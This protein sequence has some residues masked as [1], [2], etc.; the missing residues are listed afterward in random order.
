MY[1]PPLALRGVSLKLCN[2]ALAVSLA[3]VLLASMTREARAQ[4]KNFEGTQVHPLAL[5][6][7]G[8][9][10]LAVN[11]PAAS[12][13][14]FQLTPGGPV[15]T[16]EIPVGFE[17]VS[18][19]AR[20]NREAWVVNWLSDSVSIVDLSTGN[21][22]R[23]IDVGDEPTDVIFAG[24]SRAM[25]FVCVSG[26]ASLLTTFDINSIGRGQVKVFDAA[27]PA[28]FP[29]TIEIF[30][31]Q[32]RALARSADG[33]R[34]F[35]SVFESGN[36][37][38]VVPETV[39]SANGGLPPPSIPVTAGGTAPATSLIVKWS[40]SKWL[41]EISRDWT[42]FIPYTLADID[43]AVIDAS[44]ANLPTASSITARVPSL[45]T[46]MG[47]MVFDP[48][49]QRLLVAN[50]DD[51]NNERFEPVV[52]GRFQSSRVSV[53]NAPAGTAP[54]VA[55]VSNLN[56]HVNEADTAGTDAE[57]ALSLALPADIAR[58][59]DG[60]VYVAATSSAKV[61]VLD[62]S[63]AVQ[64]RIGVGNGPTGLAVDDARGRLYVL[65]RFDQTLSVVDTASKIQTAVVPVGF[66]I[67]PPSVR[68]G[69]RFLYDATNFS[70]HG[71][72]SCASCHPNGHRDGLAW[73]L[74]NPQGTA[75]VVNTVLG[76]VSDH[77][78]KGPMTTQ[79]LRGLSGVEPLHWRGDRAGIENFNPAFVSL[80]GSTRQLTAQEMADFKAFVQSLTYPP[81]PNEFLGR[82]QA[83]Q[84]FF[85][86]EPLDRNIAT[87]SSCHNV[88]NFV[89]G[90]NKTII[91]KEA[92]MKT[93]A[94]KVPQLRG[95]YQ[96]LGMDKTS[97]EKLTGFGFGHDGTFDTLFNFQTAPQFDFR[98]AGDVGTANAWRSTIERM[99]LQL[100]TG[101]PPA[102]G[103][104]VTVDATN[105][106]FISITNDISTLIQQAAVGNCD[107]V[108]RGLYGGRPRSFL[109]V[110]P[111]GP[112]QFQPDTLAEAPVSLQTLLNAVGAN[113]EL[114]FMGV[115]AGE[116]PLFAL[117]QDG[118]GILNDDEPRTSVSISG[119]VVNAS[120]AP[121]AGVAVTLS[122]SQTA[123]TT[124]DSLGRFLFT[125]ASVSGTHTVTPAAQ[126]VT[127]EPQSRT[128]AT[129]RADQ[130][131]VFISAAAN[132]SDSSEFFVRQH[133]NDFFSREPD[134]AG[135][136]FWINEIES[137]GASAQ[138]REV[139]RINVSGAFFL[140]IEFQ[141][142]GFLVYK[143]YKA[144]FGDLAGKPV[145][146]TLDQLMTD[147]QRIGRNLIV[148][149]GDWQTLL[150][151]NKRAF[152]LG[153]VQRP[154]FLARFPVGTSAASFV[155]ALN[156]NTGGSL[157]GERDAIV[158]QLNSNNTTQGR[159]TALRSVVEN[160]EFTRREKNRA[161]VLMQ[162]FG[163]L[164]RNPDDAPQI[165]L[166]FEGY[167]FWLGKLDDNGGDFVHAEMVKAFLSSD[168][169]RHRFG[170]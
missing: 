63:G 31:K 113:A 116:G 72:V 157:G 115:P 114:T 166:N 41:D 62:A 29:T 9:R 169:Y 71:T 117:D 126:G 128:F 11:T 159:A 106:S 130:S 143:S 37:T 82:P 88:D 45:G 44:G 107:L 57:R 95:L 54:T 19:A 89:P 2:F 75:D 20:N 156:A 70:A 100:D 34:V 18:V 138:C 47:N 38:T 6:P 86:N 65:N 56:S 40:G 142:T 5:T 49:S 99:I 67:E 147:T 42:S 135:L 124:T 84:S 17:P 14:V 150:E 16:A 132:A 76:Q 161:F 23:T 144:S 96:K 4:F 24:S 112:L 131:G 119:R 1:P 158:N 52:R 64:T 109:R 46:H 3:A 51:I 30:G 93:Q 152:F 165:G 33:S 12:L 149:Q 26:G 118:N 154:E 77:P 141:Q 27:N 98:S 155:D 32:P 74:G 133:Y 105:K 83:N 162:Y 22:V 53:L 92:L 28:S 91:N 103:S 69:R 123:T 10:L 36:Q 145:P 111:N 25:A 94:F 73:D 66:N 134:A 97:G 8:T 59:S 153:W 121:L 102:V 104:I 15:L 13:S 137:C 140:S 108:V 101:T 7:D 61:G 146:A 55:S 136:A 87:C 168:E 68:N 81:N 43:L 80:L 90:T 129:P 85:N 50:L 60:T 127:F 148:N 58:S 170:L 120:G 78:M 160:A 35:V 122:G 164:R 125:R 163:Y 110:P 139:K 39:V 48:V 79:S 151:T 167:L 21:V